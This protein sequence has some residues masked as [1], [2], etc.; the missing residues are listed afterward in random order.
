[1]KIGS[2][3]FI[4]YF[5]IIAV[6]VTATFSV[7]NIFSQRY[8]LNETRKQL[9]QEGQLVANLFKNTQ[10]SDQGAIRNLINRNRIEVANRFID[11]NVVILN[12]DKKIIYTNTKTEDLRK[13]RDLINQEKNKE[14]VSAR[15]PVENNN[16]GIRGYILLFSKIKD[17]KGL[18]NLMIGSQLLSFLV[19]A[20]V[21]M[22]VGYLLQRGLTKPIR[23]LKNVITNFNLNRYQQVSINTGDEIEELAV[24]FN[25]MAEKLQQYDEQQKRFL[26]NASHE[27]KTPLMAIQG[28]AEAIMEGIVTKEEINDSLAV[29]IGESQRLKKLVD[30]ITYLTKL[31][32]VN[33]V[34]DFESTNV[35]HIIDSAVRNLKSLAE[36]KGIK[37]EID[38]NFDYTGKF[39]VAKLKQAFIN[40]IGNCLRYAKSRIIISGAIQ[41][42][43][44][45]LLFKDDGTGFKNGEEKKI[46]DRFYKGQEGGTGIGLAIT[47]SIIEGHGGHIEAYSNIPNGAVFQITFK[48]NSR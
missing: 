13:I 6:T 12:K 11:A 16:E 27:L 35:K 9:R 41:N 37:I 34:F 47:K 30:E 4:T 20:F 32:S 7:Y 24:S 48:K 19:A 17:V 40:I 1:M 21:A 42:N 31:E 15:I 5:L 23:K 10:L 2:K 18:T 29:I 22:V 45:E 39:D 8:M 43:G 3:I 14:Y 33:E 28:N 26:Q 36:Q 38:D 46:F 44:F 25:Q